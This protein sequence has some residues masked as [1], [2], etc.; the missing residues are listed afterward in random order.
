LAGQLDL[1]EV[2]LVV[3][4]KEYELEYILRSLQQSGHPQIHGPQWSAPTSAEGAGI[5][6]C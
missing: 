5:S 4:Q 6:H 3:S 1:A 2:I